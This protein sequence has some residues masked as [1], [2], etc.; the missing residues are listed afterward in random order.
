[1]DM[2]MP[3]ILTAASA[4]CRE[5]VSSRGVIQQYLTSDGPVTR[6][7]SLEV[8]KALLMGVTAPGVQEADLIGQLCR[9]GG[10]SNGRVGRVMSVKRP[11]LP[12]GQTTFSGL[13]LVTKQSVSK[14]HEALAE[15]DTLNAPFSPFRPPRAEMGRLWSEAVTEVV[16][17]VLVQPRPPRPRAAENLL[18]ALEGLARKTELYHRTTEVRTREGGGGGGGM[19]G[20][21]RGGRGGSGGDGT[22]RKRRRVMLML[23]LMPPLLLLLLLTMTMPSSQGRFTP[24]LGAETRH[25]W[26]LA[27]K[28]LP[29]RAAAGVSSSLAALV[30]SVL[31]PFSHD[32]GHS[33]MH[34]YGDTSEVKRC[35]KLED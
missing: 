32:H 35:R 10:G 12:Q 17:G 18:E 26:Q 25:G 8:T 28:R 27:W 20:S 22:R 9:P 23:M 5:A 6:P 24:V 19:P 15:H 2:V 4:M 30:D 16:F 11:W 33:G 21:G 29:R 1:M 7:A 14:Y 13:L 31:D 3:Q 34:Y